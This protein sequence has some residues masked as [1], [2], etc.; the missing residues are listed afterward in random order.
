MP[1]AACPAC[2]TDVKYSRDDD[3]GTEVTCPECDEVFVPPK[4]KP[5]PKKEKK[6][7]VED[8][9]TYKADAAIDDA[10]RERKTKRVAAAVHHAREQ[11]KREMRSPKR[12]FFGGP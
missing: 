7:S 9:D 4:L 5:K 1:W 6:Y 3:I 2:Q 12:P 8:E 11:K 10:D